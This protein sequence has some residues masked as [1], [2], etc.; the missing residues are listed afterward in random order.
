MDQFSRVAK[1][2]MALILMYAKFDWTPDVESAFQ[3]L[4][5]RL[6]DSLIVKF[7]D[8]GISF[9]LAADA[10]KNALGA[11]SSRRS[12][13]LEHPVA[14]ASCQLNKAEQNYSATEKECLALVWA[15]WHFRYYVYGHKF[16]IVTDCR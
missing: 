8:F 6:V 1:P 2:L 9:I 5:G 4:K 11:V 14:F 10:L 7:P 15:V 3:D 13:S 16:K 12:G